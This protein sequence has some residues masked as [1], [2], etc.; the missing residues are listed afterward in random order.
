MSNKDIYIATGIYCDLKGEESKYFQVGGISSSEQFQSIYWRCVVVNFASSVRNNPNANHILFTN[1][2]YIP[3]IG[4]FK[5]EEF[6]L[7]LGIKIVSLPFTYQPPPG[8]F[9]AWRN[10]FYMFDIIKYFCNNCDSMNDNFIILDSDCVWIDSADGIVKLLEEYGLISYEINYSY[11]HVVNGLSR[12]NMRSIYEEMGYQTID[13]AP[14]YFGAEICAA[15]GRDIIKLSSEIDFIWEISLKRFADHQPRF[16]TEEH[17]LSFAYNKLGYTAGTA[18]FYIK[19]IWTTLFNYKNACDEDFE[20][21]IWHV[22]S[23]KKY[24]IKRL[25]TQVC[26]S[27]S[28]FWKLPI[29]KPFAQ[30]VGRYLGIPQRTPLKF[31]LDIFDAGM[32]KLQNYF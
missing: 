32:F 4:K 24:G 11:T 31:T 26:N 15:K 28:K 19:R 9:G 18:N 29:G 23:E 7:N 1:L 13:E 27:E 2:N 25:F 5:T 14:K 3:N 6:F 22:P 17:M 8:Y 16:N 30:Y 10:T 12:V 21:N 20:L